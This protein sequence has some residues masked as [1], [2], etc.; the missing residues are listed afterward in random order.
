M[1]APARRAIP[2]ALALV[3]VLAHLPLVPN[4]PGLLHAD[5]APTYL[6]ADAIREGRWSAFYF[7]LPYGGTTL[8][9]LRAAWGLPWT[10]ITRA[11]EA[12]LAA[13]A[14]FTYL[15]VPSFF[16][17]CAYW[18]AGAYVSSA[19]AAAVGLVAAVGFPF[20][21][22]HLANDVY[23]AYLLIG[24]ALLAL[25]ARWR[26]PFLEAPLPALAALGALCGLG[27]YTS[28]AALIFVVAFL[29]PPR[30]AFSEL[31]ALARDAL[32]GPAWTRVFFGLAVALLGLFAYLEVFGPELGR[33]GDRP[34]KLH[35]H[36]N[37]HL[38]L[39]LLGVLWL[40]RRRAWLGDRELVVRAAAVAG[41]F[42]LGLAP[43]L[44]HWIGLGVPPPAGTGSPN[45]F[46]EM[47]AVAGRIPLAI[48]ELVGSP[49]GAGRGVSAVLFGAGLALLFARARRGPRLDGV[50]F[51]AALACLAFCRIH[52]YTTGPTRYL[53]PLL[54]ALLVGLGLLADE[55][56]RHRR[57]AL[58]ALGALLLAF[59]LGD[60]MAGRRAAI[61]E[62]RPAETEAREREIVRRFRE[63]DVPLVV[64]DD[65]W[66]S[67]QYS[68]LSRL[69]PPFVSAEAVA[70][71]PPEGVR[72]LASSPG[73]GLLLGREEKIGAPV[74]FR[75]GGS[76][77]IRAA[78]GQ[79]GDRFLY[80]ADRAER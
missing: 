42:V 9:W 75:D 62:L 67:N 8:T 49:A 12:P 40:F 13:N 14:A 70:L 35:A 21:D 60:A 56:L 43:E 37:L 23:T 66:H 71:R 57:R 19:A 2:P 15:F 7:D 20:L 73:A 1:T 16:A 59:H 72:R 53:L 11:P 77:K 69:E 22:S 27:A 46:P 31:K 80:V 76:W 38:A 24:M 18:L 32:R 79:V 6:V 39:L 50:A 78:L 26:S 65:Y 74:A 52:T 34:I 17:I 44:A 51:S 10:A 25:R 5:Y 63:A 4:A 41:G 54:P 48:R 45:G 64:S 3:A 47:V 36:P 30:W 68:V 33:L 29:L 55:L 58:A 28:R 61:A